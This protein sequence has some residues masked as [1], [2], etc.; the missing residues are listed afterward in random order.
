MKVSW[1]KFFYILFALVGSFFLFIGVT[2]GHSFLSFQQKSVEQTAVIT[3]IEKTPKRNAEEITYTVYVEY[4]YR[5]TV[6]TGKLSYYSASMQVG[7][8]ITIHLDPENPSR[9]QSAASRWFPVLFCVLGGAA[10]AVGFSGWI[11]LEVKRRHRKRLLRDGY[12]VMAEIQSIA[13]NLKFSVN[14]RHPY[15]IRLQWQ[16][17]NK[18]HIFLSE[19]IWY[20]PRERLQAAGI[21]MLPVYLHRK[22]DTLYYVS[23]EPLE[24]Q[25][26]SAVQKDSGNENMLY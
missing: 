24:N 21:T 1:N 16:E 19:N 6:Y 5:G 3:Q 12:R 14:G 11:A 10:A 25:E 9:I 17:G 18:T 8:E 22:R 26:N 23:L 20:N 15:R 7:K 13:P 2:L 4:S